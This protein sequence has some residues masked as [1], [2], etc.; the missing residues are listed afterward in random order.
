ETVRYF[1]LA[2]T[3]YT[4][5]PVRALCISYGD[6]KEVKAYKSLLMEITQE[7]HQLDADSRHVS[8][9]GNNCD[10]WGETEGNF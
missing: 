3:S 8:Y 7:L 9:V 5:Y 10:T 1:L 2:T 6:Q 4:N